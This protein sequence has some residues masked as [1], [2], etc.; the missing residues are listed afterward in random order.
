MYR[1][2]LQ[3]CWFY[4]LQHRFSRLSAKGTVQSLKY[5][6]IRFFNI[7]DEAKAENRQG[8]SAGSLLLFKQERNLFY[9]MEEDWVISGGIENKG[10]T[11]QFEGQ[12]H[13]FV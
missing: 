10:I 12:K 4:Q 1:I 9:P 3:Q 8:F 2:G 7:L 5:I 11:I 6:N 13:S